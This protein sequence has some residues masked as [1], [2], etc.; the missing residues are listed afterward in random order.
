M[1]NMYFLFIFKLCYL[2]FIVSFFVHLFQTE[3]KLNFA[4]FWGTSKEEP[5]FRVC[6]CSYVIVV[7][8]PRLFPQPKNLKSSMLLAVIFPSNSIP[9][10]YPELLSIFRNYTSVFKHLSAENTNR[11]P[12]VAG[13]KI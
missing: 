12:A 6:S 11:K 7:K 8:K 4:L 2:I 3:L 13:N 10:S 9:L 5:S 1:D